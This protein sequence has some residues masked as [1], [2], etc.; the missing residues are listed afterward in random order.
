MSTVE[1]MSA[2]LI[3]A[4]TEEINTKYPHN[5]IILVI[6]TITG[7][8]DA[9]PFEKT[10]EGESL[11]RQILGIAASTLTLDFMIFTNLPKS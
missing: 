6:D 7:G 2:M 5:W 3:D 10:E 11:A 8:V 9:L 1:T 4:M